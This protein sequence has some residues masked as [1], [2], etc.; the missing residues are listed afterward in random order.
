MNEEKRD[1]AHLLSLPFPLPHLMENGHKQLHFLFTVEKRKSVK[2]MTISIIGIQVNEIVK[3]LHTSTVK[4]FEM[5][6]LRISCL[7]KCTYLNQIS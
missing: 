2:Q 1:S 4:R 3:D 7:D 6:H 5:Q